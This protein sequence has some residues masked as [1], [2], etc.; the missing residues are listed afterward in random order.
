MDGLYTMP[1]EFIVP[2][3]N[4]DN[5]YFFDH[6]V[7][8]PEGQ[9]QPQIKHFRFWGF[10]ATPFMEELIKNELRISDFVSEGK[11]QE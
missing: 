6:M 9:Q 11:T 2:N 1:Y 10:Q 4:P 8:G 7:I 3:L 5:I